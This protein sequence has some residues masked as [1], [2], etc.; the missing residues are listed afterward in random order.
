MIKVQLMDSN[1]MHGEPKKPN[2]LRRL[3]VAINGGLVVVVG[4]IM[5]PYPGPGWVVVF[6]GLAILSKEYPW[7]SRLLKWAK[8]KYNA[9]YAWV[10]IQNWPV[11]AVLALFTVIVVVGTLWLVNAYG[12]MANWV[13]I[14]WPWLHSPL[15]IFN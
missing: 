11:R 9:F 14:D 3:L 4:I 8:K 12:I 10:A 13:G 2:K 6:A 7:A 15:P 5:V 1:D